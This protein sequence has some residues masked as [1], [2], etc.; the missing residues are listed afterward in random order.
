MINFI[1]RINERIVFLLGKKEKFSLDI[2]VAD[3]KTFDHFFKALGYVLET[4]L[5]IHCLI[6]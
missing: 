4:F 6:H 3:I 5:K 1:I 2:V